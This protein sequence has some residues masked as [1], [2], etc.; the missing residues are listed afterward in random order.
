MVPT[1]SWIQ[2]E[3]IL[4]ALQQY[5]FIHHLPLILDQVIVESSLSSYQLQFFQEETKT[6]PSQ[7]QQHT[8]SSDQSWS[9]PG[10]IPEPLQLVLFKA[11]G[12]QLSSELLLTLSPTLKNLTCI[13]WSYSSSY[14]PKYP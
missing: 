13:S 3:Y 11:E 14:H 7:Q 8:V 4:P 1:L 10:R 12:Q 2:P 5:P 6:F 9:R